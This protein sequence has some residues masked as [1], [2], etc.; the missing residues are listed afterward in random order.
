M[1]NA[2]ARRT[3]LIRF[4]LGLL[5]LLF[6]LAAAALLFEGYR[7]SRVMPG[8]GWNSQAA[9]LIV[10][11]LVNLV[12]SAVLVA[13][14]L[15]LLWVRAA[16]A[17]P[18]LRG[19]HLEKPESEF[20]VSDAEPGY[21]LTDYLKQE[22]R[23]FQELSS[24]MQTSWA[25][26]I[27]GTG[28]YSRFRE[29]SVCNPET[30]LDRNWN[31]SWILEA[32]DPV[33][34]VLLLHGLSDSPYSLRQLGL[35]L[36]AE[37]YTVVWLRLPGH[38][39]NP[40]ALADVSW[41]DWA[42]AVKIAVCGLRKTLPPSTPLI[43]GGYSNGGAL[44]VDYVLA[45]LDDPSLPQA[46]AV[47]LFSPMIGIN[48]LARLTRLYHTVA[49]VSRT[50]KA[51]WSSIQA[52]IDPFKYS[53]WPMNANVQA[54]SVTQR[55][56]RKLAAL[57]KSG[58]IGELPPMLAMQSVVDSTV[59]V[60]KLITVLFD[61]LESDCSELFL[62]DVNRVDQ[63]SNLLNL[64]FEK[65]V[66]PRLQRTDRPY[67]LTVLTNTRT[68]SM[69]LSLKIHRRGEVTEQA[70]EL[71]WPPGIV[72]LSHIAVPIPLDDPIYGAV[73]QNASG[74]SLGTLAM[75]AEPSA[76]LIS[77]SIFV[78]SRNNPFYN[79]MEDRVVGWLSRNLKPDSTKPV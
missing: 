7:I 54:W 79:F 2:T 75:R 74:L 34:G 29:D 16:R 48:P 47:V 65:S 67:Q 41:Q 21:E 78:R 55:V 38:G 31:R 35:R 8:K 56:E 72:S 17:L 63:L 70:T 11:V 5:V 14:V 51:Q 42:A 36:H 23:V 39:T 24:L 32:S 40:R 60:S 30:I 19:W 33:G 15:L 50:H 25:E 37:G 62:F 49:L 18:D 61:Q 12:F 68:S 13:A 52:E 53:S 6:F 22:E 64:S 57:R 59:E 3:I 73:P 4:L 26:Q 46:D 27:P 20:Q 77:S 71:L 66:G 45:A 1:K 44:S 76:I 69:Q 9:R 10:L 58:R 43:L 28:T